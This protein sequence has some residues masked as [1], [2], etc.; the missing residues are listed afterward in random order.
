MLDPWMRLVLAGWVL[1]EIPG[2]AKQV[3]AGGY[4]EVTGHPTA[5]RVIAYGVLFAVIW[6]CCG[7]IK[8]GRKGL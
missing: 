4:L 1:N 7:L 6:A 8:E 5:D 2:F 3:T